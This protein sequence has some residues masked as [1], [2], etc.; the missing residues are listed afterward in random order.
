[1]TG[2]G[3]DANVTTL[4]YG[5]QGSWILEERRWVVRRTGESE[6]EGYWYCREY[7]MGRTRRGWFTVMAERGR[8]EESTA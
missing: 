5:S 8:V 1:M 2:P 4:W 3:T 7:G 6:G